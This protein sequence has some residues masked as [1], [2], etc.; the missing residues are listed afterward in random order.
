MQK[1]VSFKQRQQEGVCPGGGG[2]TCVLL[3]K[4]QDMQLPDYPAASIE[5]HTMGGGAEH[6]I[7]LTAEVGA[8]WIGGGG[9]GSAGVMLL[10]V[11]GHLL[12][13]PAAF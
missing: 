11:L 9:V 2:Q 10:V 7:L 13:Y 12:K 4:N 3:F 6:C 5:A 1:D 8:G